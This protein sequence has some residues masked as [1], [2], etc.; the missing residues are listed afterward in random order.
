[1]G[2]LSRAPETLP[3]A[4][5]LICVSIRATEPK[6]RAVYIN[7]AAVLERLGLQLCLCRNGECT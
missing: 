4:H 2:R 3:L 7:E 5:L 6:S 1:M